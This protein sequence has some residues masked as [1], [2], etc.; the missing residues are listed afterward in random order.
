LLWSGEARLLRALLDVDV[1]F[2]VIVFFLLCESASP[3]SV[4]DD[5]SEFS[6]TEGGSF[7]PNA[8]GAGSGPFAAEAI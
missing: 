5:C 1:R 3:G 7:G 4:D 8:G 2:D 6:V